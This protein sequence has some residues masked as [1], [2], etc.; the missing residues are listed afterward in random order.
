MSKW[1]CYLFSPTGFSFLSI[2]FDPIFYSAFI[3]VF[4]KECRFDSLMH[5]AIY[6]SILLSILRLKLLLFREQYYSDSSQTYHK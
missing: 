2:Y 3:L 4:E 1:S 6:S 5:S